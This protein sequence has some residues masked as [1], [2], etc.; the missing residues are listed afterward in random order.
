MVISP[1][2]TNQRVIVICVK[3]SDVPATRL[4]TA[5]DWVAILNRDVNQFY[6][7]A[8][9]NQTDFLFELPTGGPADGWFTIGPSSDYNYYTTGQLAIDTVDPFVNFN[10]Y[11]RVLIITNW[12]GFGGQG[13]GFNWWK[14]ADGVEQTFVEDGRNVGRRQMSLGI[15]NEW[16]DDVASSFDDGAAVIGHEI[17]HQLDLPTHYFDVRFN[18]GMTRE[19]LTPW[20]IMG[21]SPTLNHFI[22]WA[23][24]HRGWIPAS[25]ILTLGPPTGTDIDSIYTLAAQE[26]LLPTTGRQLIKIPFA[27]TGPFQ[28]YVVEFRRQSNGDER[29]PASGVLISLINEAPGALPNCIVLDNPAFP[30]DSNRAP[31]RVGDSFTDPT[32]DITITFVRQRLNTAWVRIRYPLPPSAKPDPMIIPWGAPPY[33]TPDIWIDSERNGWGTYRYND[34]AG[35][36][37]G[38]GD[39]VWVSRPDVA[40]DNRVYVRIRNLGT[41]VATN[42]RVEVFVNDPP[43]LG[44]RGANWA[45]L[46]TILF[47]TI[48]AGDSR[49]DFV[50]WRTQTAAHTCLKARIV[51]DP[52]ETNALNNEAQENVTHFET[53]EGSPWKPI[54]VKMEVSNPHKEEKTPVHIHVRDIP[55]GWAIGIEPRDLVL[56]ANGRATVQV[57]VYPAGAP[58]EEDKNQYRDKYRPGFIGKPK[59]E[60]LVPFGDTFIPIGGVDVWT[61]LVKPSKL[62]VDWKWYRDK[63]G[64]IVSGLLEPAATEAPI[65]VEVINPKN[66]FTGL[67]RTNPKGQFELYIGN[68]EKG[69]YELQASFAGDD[70]LASAESVP[71]KMRLR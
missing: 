13:A 12:A 37:I 23:K 66:R 54:S 63:Q 52:A 46:G 55:P 56:E 39:P 32:R 18:P 71:V 44:D 68:L 47:P 69:T 70:I 41:R 33:E 5:A 34:G 19:V 45:F 9:F 40:R 31:L 11:N 7:Q 16:A 36:P 67:T 27:S 58:G 24:A 25:R 62:T 57:T 22:G 28:G 64:I 3:Y 26:V 49:Q 10:R 15:I 1:I 17:G 53:T 8:T 42:V 30:G 61:H 14:V 21:F 51:H 2:G 29:L 48:P 38:N 4:A 50:L 20:D 35:N 59:V 43:G 6:R 60:A 65:V